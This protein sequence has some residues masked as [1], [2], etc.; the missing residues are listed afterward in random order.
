[1][2]EL[3]HQHYHDL[4]RQ[5]EKNKSA[6]NNNDSDLLVIDTP[7]NIRKLIM[8][9]RLNIEPGTPESRPMSDQERKAFINDPTLEDGVVIDLEEWRKKR[10]PNRAMWLTTREKREAP[11]RPSWN[12]MEIPYVKA[13]DCSKPAKVTKLA[14]QSDDNCEPETD[15]I[16]TVNAT[17]KLLQKSKAFRHKAVKC[18]IVETRRLFQC[19]AWDHIATWD[20]KSYFEI[21]REVST[22]ECTRLATQGELLDQTGKSRRVKTRGTT[23]LNYDMVGRTWAEG[24]EIECEGQDFVLDGQNVYDAIIHIQQKVTIVDDEVLVEND[25]LTAKGDGQALPCA[26][27]D[28]SC[29]TPIATYTWT[30]EEEDKCRFY[31]TKQFEARIVKNKKGEEVVM[32]ADGSLIRLLKMEEEIQCGEKVWTTS[33]DNL[34]LVDAQNSKKTWK[35]IRPEDVSIQTYVANRDDFVFNMV[36]HKVKEEFKAV[37]TQTCHQF[38][39]AEKFKFFVQQQQ[40]GLTAW[41]MGNGTFATVGGEVMFRYQCREVLTTPRETDQCYLSLPVSIVQPRELA[42]K[43]KTWFVEPNTRRL[44]MEGIAVPCSLPMAPNI[45]TTS[46]RWISYGK[47]VHYVE[48]PGFHPVK[49]NWHDLELDQE[50]LDWQSGGVYSRDSVEEFFREFRNRNIAILYGLARQA[51]LSASWQD[52][53]TVSMDELFP[54]H[55]LYATMQEK[56]LGS[57]LS[58]VQKLG[59]A[60]AF[61]IG[62]YSICT[63]LRWLAVTIQNGTIAYRVYGCTTQIWQAFCMNFIVMN[64]VH[65]K[66][67]SNQRRRRQHDLSE[68]AEHELATLQSKIPEVPPPEYPEL[69]SS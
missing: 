66:R 57:F 7:R 19:G 2:L 11:S 27:S 42:K 13:W 28:R 14:F 3:K 18:S 37:M 36:M 59:N 52:K 10:F 46:G 60:A 41:V 9:P 55:D 53:G 29:V 8:L 23:I 26:E 4:K 6:T 32:S 15:I 58:W 1:M 24:G 30:L 5:L 22:A 68:V 35:K 34:F 63:V 20:E 17:F 56:L 16:S 12:N 33:Y 21:P 48:A 39:D 45:K 40:P 38:R 61:C 69:E 51:Q 49:F 50:E 47:K 64:E 62:L 43:N 65:K 31:E 25:V 67:S 54:H 44:T